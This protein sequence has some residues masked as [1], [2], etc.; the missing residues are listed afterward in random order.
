M[1]SCFLKTSC[2]FFAVSAFA[3]ASEEKSHKENIFILPNGA[4]LEMVW[5]E[6][7]DFITGSPDTEIGREI[8][9]IQH[10]V[11]ITKG[12]WIGKYEI[13][14][15]QWEKVM[16]TQPWEGQI[17]FKKDG[18][19]PAVYISWN[20]TQDFIKKIN[21]A[22]GKEIYRLPTEAEWEY[23]CRAGTKSAYSFG[24]DVSK[25]DDY[26]WHGKNTYD[27]G[28]YFAHK[29]GQKLPNPWG[30]Y[31]MHGN[32]WE[33]VHDFYGDYPEE[34][35]IDPKG[36]ESSDN[37]VFRGGSFYYLSRFARSAYRGYNTPN[38]RLFNLGFRIVRQE[39]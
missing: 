34:P 38:H 19:Y 11:T 33:W 14:Q 18:D 31:D 22:E 15:G 32:V 29:V 39:N 6:A 16:N 3:F 2:I 17:F 4:E 37:H 27:L 9:E 5:I 21:E 30:I 13:T 28:N 10:K 36:P 7:G 24:D 25:L 20:D 26:G 35:Q 1:I 12:F 23:A 8:N